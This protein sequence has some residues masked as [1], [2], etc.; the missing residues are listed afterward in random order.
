MGARILFRLSSGNFVFRQYPLLEPVPSNQVHHIL[1]EIPDKKSRRLRA[2]CGFAPENFA[3]EK[4]GKLLE[5]PPAVV[6]SKCENLARKRKV[7][8]EIVT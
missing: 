1:L 2:M 4:V 6:C 8:S 7:L 5:L 3:W